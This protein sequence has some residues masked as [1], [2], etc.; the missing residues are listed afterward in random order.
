[1]LYLLTWRN[2]ITIDTLANLSLS[3]RLLAA[4]SG[5]E[6]GS[7]AANGL[8]VAFVTYPG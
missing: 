8:I 4:A 7:L 1:V 5:Q 2:R 6:I 3:E